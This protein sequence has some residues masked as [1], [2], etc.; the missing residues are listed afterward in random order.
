MGCLERIYR[1]NDEDY[2]YTSYEFYNHY[3]ESRTEI[4]AA[5]ICVNDRKSNGEEYFDIIDVPTDKFL[6]Y[7]FLRDTYPWVS[8]SDDLSFDGL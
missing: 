2:S 5:F 1:L 3:E 8:V 6:N 4:S 7:L